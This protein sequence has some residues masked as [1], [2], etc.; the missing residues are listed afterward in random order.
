MINNPFV[1]RTLLIQPEP[2]ELILAGVKTWEIRGSR[3]KI[4]ET[5]GLI[6]SRSG[7]VV[8]VC[9]LVDCVGPLTGQLFRTNAAKAG[10]RPREAQLGYYQETYAWVLADIRVL[11]KPV[12]YMHPSGA[13][14]W[15]KLEGKTEAAIRREIP[16]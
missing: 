3:T 14:I 7:T 2:M 15:V 12:P 16:R 1:I 8:A 13:I 5:I 6:P 11:R 10:I 4:R 9:D